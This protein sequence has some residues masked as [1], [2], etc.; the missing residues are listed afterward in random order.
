MISSGSDLLE[1]PYLHGIQVLQ[2]LHDN[3]G[4]ST[5]LVEDL[6]N[7]KLDDYGAGHAWHHLVFTFPKGD[8]VTCNSCA[9]CDPATYLIKTNTR[10]LSCARKRWRL[11]PFTSILVA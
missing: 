10:R 2:P 8:R 7:Y 11:A 1:E 9:T 3:H 4:F 6:W 5:E